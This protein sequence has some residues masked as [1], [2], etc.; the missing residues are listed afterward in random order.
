[1]SLRIDGH[2]FAV[3]AGADDV[4]LQLEPDRNGWA[5]GRIRLWLRGKEIH[6]GLLSDMHEVAL[7]QVTELDGEKRHHFCLL[8]RGAEPLLLS[9]R[10]DSE[11]QSVRALPHSF[12]PVFRVLFYSAQHVLLSRAV[13][14]IIM[15]ATGGRRLCRRAR[16]H[17]SAVAHGLTGRTAAA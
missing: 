13:C 16:S 3:V 14:S 12:F 11:R 1:M 15:V 2:F 17:A 10:I 4:I 7:G 6:T 5:E 8:Y 9:T